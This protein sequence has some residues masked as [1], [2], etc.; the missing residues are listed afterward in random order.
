[1]TKIINNIDVKI[2]NND[3]INNKKNIINKKD[4][5]ENK[6]DIAINTDKSSIKNNN[7]YKDTKD[8]KEKIREIR[9]IKPYIGKESKYKNAHSRSNKGVFI[10]EDLGKIELSSPPN[11]HRK[12][13]KFNLNKSQE[14]LLVQSERVNS[15]NKISEDNK[16]IKTNLN[17]KQ[18]NS[19]KIIS[20][21]IKNL[22]NT[23]S[24]F[25]KINSDNN[26]FTKTIKIEEKLNKRNPKHNSHINYRKKI[27]SMKNVDINNNF[28][29]KTLEEMFENNRNVNI[30]KSVKINNHK[31]RDIYNNIKKLLKK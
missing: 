28:F 5:I 2:S 25:P 10:K 21:M 16:I 14:S 12:I 1:M 15:K 27:L 7:N 23:Y 11:T 4:I 6:K 17:I 13:T 26:I 24:N 18:K 30:N 19:Y 3:N 31:Y 8:P 20:P 22:Y 9:E 29:E